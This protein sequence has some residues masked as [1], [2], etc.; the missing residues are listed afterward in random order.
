MKIAI[1]DLED[2]YGRALIIGRATIRFVN[3]WRQLLRIG[4]FNWYS[5]TLIYAYFEVDELTKAYELC[6]YLLGFGL[7]V[8]Y[9]RGFECSRVK[10]MADEVWE[11]IKEAGV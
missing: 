9:D 11:E 2:S 5:F 8:R 1:K 3:E 4:R 10:Q 7:L 6:L